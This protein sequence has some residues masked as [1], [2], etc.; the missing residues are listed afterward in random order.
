ML[1]GRQITIPPTARTPA[2][3]M[4]G[5]VDYVSR[6]LHHAMVFRDP[7]TRF[8]QTLFVLRFRSLP[9]LPLELRQ[10]LLHRHGELASMLCRD[11][12]AQHGSYPAPGC[13]PSSWIQPLVFRGCLLGMEGRDGVESETARAV[14]TS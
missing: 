3:T 12:G 7:F 13:T 14:V 11:D 4:P 10:L 5:K 8:F 1:S 6:T 9:V 2:L